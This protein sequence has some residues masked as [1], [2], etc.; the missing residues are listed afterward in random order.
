MILYMMVIGFELIILGMTLHLFGFWTYLAVGEQLLKSQSADPFLTS[1]M[2]AG[3]SNIQRSQSWLSNIGPTH[4]DTDTVSSPGP[5]MQ[6]AFLSP[7]SNKGIY[8]IKEQVVALL[9][10]CLRKDHVP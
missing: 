8:L 3:I 2:D 9:E 1:E 7:L 6:D 10:F 5:Q 4:R